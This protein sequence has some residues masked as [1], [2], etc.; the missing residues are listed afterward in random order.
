MHDHIA[1]GGPFASSK[2]KLPSYT[3]GVNGTGA[4]DGRR[5]RSLASSA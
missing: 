5:L 4:Y 1:C 2:S 3:V